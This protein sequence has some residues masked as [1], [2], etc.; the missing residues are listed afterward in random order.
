MNKGIKNE[1]TNDN[2]FQFQI[3]TFLKYVNKIILICVL[4]NISNMTKFINISNIYIISNL[5]YHS[6]LNL[7][8][9]NKIKGNKLYNN[10][11]TRKYF[12]KT[13]NINNDYF[14]KTKLSLYNEYMDNKNYLNFLK[15]YFYSKL[16]LSGKKYI[17]ITKNIFNIIINKILSKISYNKNIYKRHLF[18]NFTL[19]VFIISI[20]AL[21][22]I[23]EINITVKFLINNIILYL[24]KY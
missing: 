1:N 19:I 13:N 24:I 23:Q 3:F 21:N 6:Y 15:K 11:S 17:K 10:S 16:L 8:K 9:T 22:A 2:L 12:S 18:C 5:F 4:S 14:S 20:K 7:D